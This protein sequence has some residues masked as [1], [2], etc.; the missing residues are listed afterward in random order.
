MFNNKYYKQVDDVAMRSPLGPA[1]ANIFMCSFE[2]KW[3]RDCPNDFK[4]VF[5]KRYVDEIFALFSSPYHADKFK[6]YLS[7]K[8]SNINF[9]IE[10]EKD[11]CLPFLDVNIFRENEKFAIT[12][13]EKRPAVWFIR[14]WLIKSLLFRCFSLCSD[15]V[16]FHHEIDKLK[17]IL[18]KSS[19]PDDLIDKCIK[20]FLNKILTP[21][22]VVSTVPK[23]ELIITLLYLG[24]NYSHNEK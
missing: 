19:Y 17:S 24:K 4:P 15:F 20:E 10:K 18:Y 21:K 23:K 13:I 5:Y 22:P 1:L 6:E 3:L 16:K 12:S 2:S 11:S 7:S 9:S 8:H 14:T